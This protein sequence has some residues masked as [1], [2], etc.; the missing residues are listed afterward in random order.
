MMSIGTMYYF[1]SQDLSTSISQSNT[2]VEIID[3]I[4]NKVTL[5][6]EILIKIKDT[7]MNKLKKYEK[8]FIVRKAAHFFMYAV[9][10]G[11]MM[12]VVYS[13]LKRVFLSASLSFTFTFLFAVFDEKSQLAVDGRTASLRDILIDSSGALLSIIILSILFLIKNR[14]EYLFKRKSENI[15]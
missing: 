2:V 3:E 12:L 5:Q 7:I 8:H 15:T 13:F 10:G 6:D 4:R 14:M 9:I 1:S 11:L